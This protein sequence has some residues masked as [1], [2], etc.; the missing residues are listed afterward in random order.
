MPRW[1][2]SPS[3]SAS[4]RIAH[5]AHYDALT[6]LPNRMLFRNELDHELKRFAA[7]RNGGALH[8]H[9]RI[10]GHQ[11][12]ARPPRRRRTA[13]GRCAAAARLRA[14]PDVVARLGGDEFAIVQTGVE[15][16][17]DITDLV[18]RIYEAIREP[19][20]CFGHPAY[21]R[22]PIGIALAPQRRHRP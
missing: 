2:T 11:R 21:R 17:A 19:Y 18:T 1:R 7:A 10:Q 5:L 12:F 15:Q 3:A 9:R 16:P 22:T 4:R 14:R 13:Q 8:R 6:D 20:E